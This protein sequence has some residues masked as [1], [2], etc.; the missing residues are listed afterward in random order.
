MFKK[1]LFDPSQ[2]IRK[3]TVDLVDSLLLWPEE[4]FLVYL[5]YAIDILLLDNAGKLSSVHAPASRMDMLAARCG[6]DDDD[7]D[8]DHDH[9]HDE[10]PMCVLAAGSQDS[11]VHVRPQGHGKRLC[12]VLPGVND[13]HTVPCFILYTFF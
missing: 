8:H 1:W 10:A 5:G 12:G 13:K 9:D 6:D 11:R 4:L 3:D 2:R 7:D